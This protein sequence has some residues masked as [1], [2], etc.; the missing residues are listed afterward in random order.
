[1]AVDLLNSYSWPG[2]VRELENCMER[3]VLLCNSDTIHAAHLPA[4]LQRSDTIDAPDGE[5][6]FE[7]LVQNFEKEIILESLEKTGGNKAKT[8]R[9]LKTTQRVIGYKIEKLGIKL[10]KGLLAS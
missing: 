7:E 2:N 1:M 5:L 6:S 3:A 9:E 4:T 8:A 10:G